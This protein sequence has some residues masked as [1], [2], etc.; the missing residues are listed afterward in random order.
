M[1]GSRKNARPAAAVGGGWGA[2]GR[3][4]PWYA[5]GL[6]F[7]CARCGACCIDH[8]EATAVILN[9]GEPERL[10]RALGVGVR[11]FLACFTRR[12]DGYLCLANR[13]KACV[14]H[15][16]EAGCRVHRAR[17]LQ[18]A[19]WP[20]WPENLDPARWQ[21]DVA[22]FCP[23]VGKGPLYPADRIERIARRMKY[24][25]VVIPG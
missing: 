3:A 10:A 1:A 21:A 13:G 14:F 2:P 9:E 19:A 15:D 25:R 12:C 23:G 7:S 17:P 16:R 8:G 22:A 6:R 5:E 4:P 18:C 24:A 11:S 20:F